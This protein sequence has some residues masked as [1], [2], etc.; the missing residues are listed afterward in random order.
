MLTAPQSPSTYSSSANMLLVLFCNVLTFILHN[1]LL[2]NITD[3]GRY[4]LAQGS[5]QPCKKKLQPLT[6]PTIHSVSTR[7][8]VVAPACKYVTLAWSGFLLSGHEQQ[9]QD[10]QANQVQLLHAAQLWT[11]RSHCALARWNCCA[12]AVT[13]LP[14]TVC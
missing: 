1:C 8:A 10:L 11:S 2:S 7:S 12:G 13:H 3:A 4:I 5:K 6:L 9:Q 14:L